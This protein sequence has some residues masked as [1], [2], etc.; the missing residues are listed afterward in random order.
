MA[1]LYLAVDIQ[2]DMMDVLSLT[3]H[4]LQVNMEP[5]PQNTCQPD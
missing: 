5:N 3:S 1:A 2:E 4:F